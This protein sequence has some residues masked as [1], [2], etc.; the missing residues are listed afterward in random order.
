MTDRDSL[1]N[2]QSVAGDRGRG[3]DGVDSVSTPGLGTESQ[4]SPQSELSPLLSSDCEAV[5]NG[6]DC[7]M[8]PA[9]TSKRKP[10]SLSTKSSTCSSPARGLYS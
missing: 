1:S 6:Y 7:N 10:T 4:C 2:L 5:K 8:S 3:V 9:K